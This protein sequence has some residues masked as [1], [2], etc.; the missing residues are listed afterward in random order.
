MIYLV[1]FMF[2][3]ICFLLGFIV[4]QNRDLIKLGE[5]LAELESVLSTMDRAKEFEKNRES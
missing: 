2:L 4:I 3:F 1:I 5:T